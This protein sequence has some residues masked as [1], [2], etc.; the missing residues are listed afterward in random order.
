MTFSVCYVWDT[1]PI[2]APSV[3]Q[4]CDEFRTSHTSVDSNVAHFFTAPTE[5]VPDNAR[6]SEQLTK[7]NVAH[8]LHSSLFVK[9]SH[10]QSPAIPPRDIT[11]ASFL[12]AVN[13]SRS[14]EF[15]YGKGTLCITT[16]SALER[17]AVT[18]KT[19]EGFLSADSRCIHISR[20]VALSD[21]TNLFQ[22]LRSL[23]KSCYAE[24]VEAK[25]L[26]Q[27]VTKH[28]DWT[29]AYWGSKSQY[30]FRCCDWLCISWFF[31]PRKPEQRDE[32]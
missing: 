5:A 3:N 16:T 23:Q 7:L 27:C 22:G 13:L 15:D 24:F 8:Y 1:K 17:K 25:F 12:S 20:R 9:A 6:M 31:F 21:G 29:P 14:F 4:H 18:S 19:L 2:V 28:K 10:T 26:I 11:E 32:L 30:P